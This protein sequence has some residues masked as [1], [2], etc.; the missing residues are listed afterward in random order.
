MLKY[1]LIHE[2]SSEYNVNYWLKRSLLIT[3]P[4][5]VGNRGAKQGGRLGGRN[6]PEFWKGA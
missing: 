3:A 4:N 6:P 2:F 5:T 1:D